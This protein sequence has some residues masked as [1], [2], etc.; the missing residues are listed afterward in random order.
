VGGYTADGNGSAEG[1]GMMLAGAADDPLAG[2]P[3]GFAGTVAPT[4]SPSWVAPH[5]S[6]DVLYAAQEAAG[7]VQ[8]FRRTGEESFV[9]LGDPVEAGAL[10]CHVA[11]APDG[12][13]LLAACWGD[14]R[15]VR[16]TLDASGRPSSPVI[17]PAA[18]DHY[19]E[20]RADAAA[21]DLD[22]A[23]AAKALREAAGEEYAHLVPDHDA[24][25]ASPQDVTTGT[26]AAPRVSRAHESLFL[27]GGVVATTDMGLDLVRIW[28]TSATGLRAAGEVV[29]PKG[30]GPRHMVWHPSGHLYVV[31]ELSHEVFVLAPD[32]AGAWRVI[33]GTPLGS[34]VLPD[35]TAAEITSSRDG[36][37]LYAGVRGSNTIA[38]LR[39]RGDGSSLEPV[40]LVEAGVDWPRNHVVVRD[41]LLVAG[42][43][44]NEVASLTLDERTGVPGAVRHRTAVPSPT[45]LLPAR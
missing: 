15:M 45:C 29:L 13:S 39:V 26:D 33:A 31:S 4:D 2:G 28:R 20:A 42:Q 32:A 25:A 22:L 37:F 36:S 10:T 35:D 3:L 21:P 18:V 17:A 23:A 14:G 12:G 8:A 16:M 11:V 5:P 7:T 9:A 38:T 40:A 41:T 43:L 44:S 34:G 30:S 1:I 19:G 24:E 6:L 27:P